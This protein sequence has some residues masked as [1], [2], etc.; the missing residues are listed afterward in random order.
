MQQIGSYVLMFAASAANVAVAVGMTESPRPSSGC[1]F[2][3]NERLHVLKLS[4]TLHSRKDAHQ[5]SSLRPQA[6]CTT[7][8]LWT[9]TLLH[10]HRLLQV[11][12]WLSLGQ[13]WWLKSSTA[14]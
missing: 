12:W 5:L 11:N 13:S 9:Q 4:A 10:V 2:A 14:W 7:S 8:V 6:T 1:C 3:I